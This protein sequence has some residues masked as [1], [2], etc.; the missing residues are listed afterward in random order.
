MGST[1]L[2]ESN[3]HVRSTQL[4]AAIDQG[5]QSQTKFTRC[6]LLQQLGRASSHRTALAL[7]QARRMCPPA[8]W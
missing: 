1:A 8:A 2:V 5:L 4:V 6:S 7:L 3:M